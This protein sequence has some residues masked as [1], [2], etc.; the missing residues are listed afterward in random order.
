LFHLVLESHDGRA[1]GADSEEKHEPVSDIDTVVVDSLKALDPD[2]RLE[3]RTLLGG[4]ARQKSAR[5]RHVRRSKQHH[6]SITSSASARRVGGIS[7]PK[8]QG[9]DLIVSALV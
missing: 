8:Q 4:L 6:Y 5:K 1:P 7:M 2:G 9:V 3:K